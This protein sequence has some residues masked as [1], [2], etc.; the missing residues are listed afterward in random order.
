MIDIGRWASYLLDAEAHGEAV[1]PI[2]S[3]EPL[4]RHDAYAIQE[5]VI[6]AKLAQGESLV[7]AKVGLVAA[8]KQAAMGID[9]PVY[10]WLTDRMRLHGSEPINTA[11]LCQPRVEPEIVFVLGDDLA[12]PGVTAERVRDATAYVCGGLEILDSR[13]RDYAFTFA[14]VVADNTS[15][16]RFILGGERAHPRDLDVPLLGCV[17]RRDGEVIETATAAAVMGDPAEAV[18]L[19]ANFLGRNGRR[20]ERDWIVLSGGM[21]APVAL[22]PGST[23]LADFHS[24]GSVSV[25]ADA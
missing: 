2:T 23:V 4:T 21:T 17:L 16:A 20:L 6:S 24:L 9:E 8:A 5:A 1:R 15:A 3:T 10:G 22:V 18:A 11:A 14:D 19:L 13:Y 25:R 12:G 7:G